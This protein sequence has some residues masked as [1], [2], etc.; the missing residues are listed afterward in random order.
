MKE[1]EANIGEL[2]AE[3]CGARKIRKEIYKMSEITTEY[4]KTMKEC[5]ANIGELHA[6]ICGARKIRKEIYKMSE[7]TKLVAD[8]EVSDWTPG[9]CTVT[10]GGGTQI[11]N[12]SV[13]IQPAYGGTG[14]PPLSM[15]R[16]CNDFPCPIDCELDLWSGWSTCSADCGGR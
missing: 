2:H 9:E 6:E 15:S 4:E 16:T 5:E 7:M 11:L 3:I 10:C 1:C 8:C 14:C 12:R 13:S